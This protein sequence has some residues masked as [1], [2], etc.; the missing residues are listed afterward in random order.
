MFRYDKVFKQILLLM[1]AFYYKE[2][3]GGMCILV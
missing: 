3:A 2:E 1:F